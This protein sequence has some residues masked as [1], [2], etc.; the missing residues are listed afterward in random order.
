MSGAPTSSESSSVEALPARFDIDGAPV[1]FLICTV[2]G[3]DFC[4]VVT[5]NVKTERLAPGASCPV[6]WPEEIPW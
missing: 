2:P 3:S 1:T 6:F 5:G 4:F